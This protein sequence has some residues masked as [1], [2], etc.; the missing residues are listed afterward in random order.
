MTLSL[1]KV[2]REELELA[3]KLRGALAD[4]RAEVGVMPADLE[5]TRVIVYTLPH[6][7]EPNAE[8]PVALVLANNHELF[9]RLTPGDGEVTLEDE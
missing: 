9:D 7:I 2:S 4:P 3:T 6:P 1:S 8:V 5:G